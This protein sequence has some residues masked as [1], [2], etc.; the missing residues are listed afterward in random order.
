MMIRQNTMLVV[1]ALAVSLIPSWSAERERDPEQ[2]RERPARV[3]RQGMRRISEIQVA[4]A[5]HV[6]ENLERPEQLPAQLRVLQEVFENRG[7]VAARSIAE[8]LG[9]RMVGDS[10]LVVV[11]SEPEAAEAVTARLE[12]LGVRALPAN[13]DPQTRRALVGLADLSAVASTEGV[14]RVDVPRMLR[15]HVVSEGVGATGAEAWQ[16][17]DPL[18]G[19]PLGRPVRLAI[20]DGGFLG[21]EGLLGTELPAAVDTQAFCG[22]LPGDI[23]G[24][25][26]SDPF[27]SAHGTAVAEIAFDMS[28]DAQ[29]LLVAFDLT[30][31]G[32]AE[33]LS[34]A[35]SYGADVVSSSVGTVFDNRDGSSALCTTA[36]A[37]KQSGA[38]WVSSAGNEGDPC[39]HEHY[40]ARTTGVEA[41]APYGQFV[42]FPKNANPILNE[43]VLD[44]GQ[45]HLLAL[46]WNAWNDPP[47]DD[48]DLFYFCDFGSGYETVSM[49]LDAQC[50]ASGTI[51]FEAVGIINGTGGPLPCGYAVL[52]FEP[53]TCPHPPG[54][55][56]D[57]WSYVVDDDSGDPGCSFL[58]ERTALYTLDSPADCEDA[59]AVG[60]VCSA[61]GGLEHYSGQ[62]PTLDQRTKPDFC[63]PDAVSTFIYGPALACPDEALAPG[64][65]GTSA[66]APHV[67]GALALLYQQ[68]GESFSVEQCLSVLEGRAR[69]VN[70][71]EQPDNQCG[72]GA[73]C[74]SASGCD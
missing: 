4:V 65:A 58:E 7:P 45:S 11:R 72:N 22:G 17:Y 36:S 14:L 60:A 71:G 29:M 66:S 12:Q 25:D 18:P 69:D 38:L 40:P 50:G 26:L 74:L 49:S 52:D 68:V 9:V 41:G 63:A 20:I 30:L 6:R 67:A 73:L 2:E 23:L 16:V 21:Y 15:Q 35:R 19:L 44:A 62:G 37:L 51:P 24:C 64:F 13:R 32:F 55:E 56:F 47:S 70:G 57:V 8:R 42:S 10:A 28:P 31:D 54:R 33:A 48:Y 1:L 61:T 46:T 5:E 3:A 53:A 39:N 43:F 27:V 34:F 59:I